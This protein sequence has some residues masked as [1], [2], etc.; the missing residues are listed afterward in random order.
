MKAKMENDSLLFPPP[1][2]F[3]G[4]NR[5]VPHFFVADEAIRLQ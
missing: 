3:I 5:V 1:A 2:A 4:R